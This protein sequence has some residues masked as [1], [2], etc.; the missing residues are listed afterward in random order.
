MSAARTSPPN[1][2]EQTGPIVV[3]GASGYTG[4]LVSAELARRGASFTVAGRSREKLE[5]LAAA[6]E[7]A[8]GVAAVPL[9]DA[10]G[11]RKQ[12]ADAAAVIACAGPFVE[13]GEPVVAAAAEAGTHYVD[14]TGEQPFIRSVFDRWG[15]IGERSGAALVSGMGFDYLPGDL[16]AALTAAELGHLEELTLAYSVRSFGPTRGTALSALGMMG[17]DDLEWVD[18]TW[19]PG[20]RNVAAGSFDFP[21]PIG[22]RRVG[23]YPAGEQIT[24][25]RHVDVDTVR[26]VIE[27]SSVTPPVLGPLA[28]PLMTATGWLMA[29]PARVVAEKAIAQLPEGPDEGARRAASFTVVCDAS[30]RLGPAA[31]RRPRQRRLWTDGGHHRRGGVADGG[32]GLRGKRRPGPGAGLRP[33]VVLGLARRP[34]PRIRGR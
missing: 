7:P 19:H 10:A 33:G 1:A 5:A 8:P 14:T 31:R 34:R 28:A 4:R 29:T 21:S 22:R 11:L 3:Y 30:L 20:S 17:A 25:P 18:G 23:R 6:L 9:D 2:P 26:E 24:V 15:A 12:L 32:A 27:L 16:L 13:H